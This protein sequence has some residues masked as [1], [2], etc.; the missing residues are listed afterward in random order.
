MENVYFYLVNH[1][2]LFPLFNVV[3]TAH[4]ETTKFTATEALIRQYRCHFIGNSEITLWQIL[5]N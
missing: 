2:L 1:L 5:I 4:S 3:L